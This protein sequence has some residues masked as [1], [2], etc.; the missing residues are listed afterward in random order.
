MKSSGQFL[1]SKGCF[2]ILP[3]LR[4]CEL[5]RN[6]CGPGHDVLSE[7]AC[8]YSF[9]LWGK[10]L[11]EHNSANTDWGQKIKTIKNEQR[12]ENRQKT[13]IFF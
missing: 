9:S 12:K 7:T 1:Q 11:H 6:C 3:G 10:S 8:C 13:R 4:F 5:M 2:V